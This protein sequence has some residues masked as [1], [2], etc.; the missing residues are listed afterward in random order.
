M[1]VRRLLVLAILLA[2]LIAYLAPLA[3]THADQDTCSFGPVSNR[4]YLEL[5]QRAKQVYAA[6]PRGY[7]WSNKETEQLLKTLH[8][9]IVAPKHLIYERIAGVHALLRA[10]GA[11]YR[12]TPAG[13]A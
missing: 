9:K 4:E 7:A 1:S 12:G 5:L 3:R 8:E 13:T 11:E 2:P 6:S 10:L